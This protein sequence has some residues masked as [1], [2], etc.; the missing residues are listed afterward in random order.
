MREA[1]TEFLAKELVQVRIAD[2]L[3][4]VRKC[5]IDSV[6]DLEPNELKHAC[7]IKFLKLVTLLGKSLE[8]PEVS[9]SAM[10]SLHSVIAKAKLS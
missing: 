10:T 9:K 5:V 7:E 4:H 1:G 8:D 6:A 3:P 2:C